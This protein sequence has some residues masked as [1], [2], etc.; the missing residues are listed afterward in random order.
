[1]NFLNWSTAVV[2][3]IGGALVVGDSALAQKK[4]RRGERGERNEKRDRRGN[5]GDQKRGPSKT[6]PT[7][8]VGGGAK[9]RAGNQGRGKADVGG[10]VRANQ[11][12]GKADVRGKVRG[13]Q[14]RGKADVRGK[15][16]G[17]QGRGKA[18]VRGKVRGNQGRGKADIRGK[19]RGNQRRGNVRGN[20]GNRGRNGR[21]RNGIGG[22]I[23]LPGL[24]NIRVRIGDDARI[25][26]RRIFNRQRIRRDDDTIRIRSGILRNRIGSNARFGL[27]NRRNIRANS[28]WRYWFSDY[29]GHHRWHRGHWRGDW[30]NRWNTR[31]ASRW[32]RFPA[33]LSFG[34]SPWGFNRTRYWFGYD[35]YYNPYYSQPVVLGSTRIDY[36]QSFAQPPYNDDTPQQGVT[37]FASARELFGQRK[38]KESLQQTH[39]ALQVMP[40]DVV[41]HEF[42]G[43]VLFALGNYDEAAPAVHSVLAVGPGWSWETM[44]DLYSDVPEYTRHLRA[45]EKHVDANPKNG[46]SHLLLGYHYVTM[47]HADAAEKQFRTAAKLNPKDQV[48]QQMVAMLSEKS[49]DGLA[50][51]PKVDATAKVDA[52]KLLGTWNAKRNGET[53]QMKLMKDNQFVWTHVKGKQRTEIKGVYAMQDGTLALEPDAG[54]VMLGNVNLE[55]DS[56]MNFRMVGATKA[57]GG[58]TF[59]K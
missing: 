44:R 56:K 17:N 1:M 5:R 28:D 36:S 48:S 24:G 41:L 43:L 18:D 59:T 34:I 15:V 20:I 6:L 25:G 57:D 50:T 30:R 51:P 13:N 42:R 12:R 23:F 55:S 54:G 45:L 40:N 33:V 31:W 38:Y 7:P 49:D 52:T 37:A 35:D 22:G 46:A 26:R 14:G 3:T 4:G 9:G 47:G 58:L 10:K 11:G 32:N 2:L 21:G 8:K 16:R 53:F 29:Y 27:G 39:A 19:I